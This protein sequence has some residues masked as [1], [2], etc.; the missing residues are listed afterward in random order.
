MSAYARLFA[1]RH[2]GSSPLGSGA[3]ASVLRAVFEPRKPRHRALRFLLGLAGVALLAVLVVVG[4]VVG[5][6]MLTLGLGY[7]LLTGGMRSAAAPTR[8]MDGEYRVVARPVLPAS[9]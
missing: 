9:R 5:A 8:V 7:R 3:L 2:F 6:V 4:I 1:S